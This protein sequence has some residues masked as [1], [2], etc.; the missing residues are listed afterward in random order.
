VYIAQSEPTARAILVPEQLTVSAACDHDLRLRRC[1]FP[2]RP[3]VL[4]L[5][6][7]YPPAAAWGS[8]KVEQGFLPPLGTISIYR[9]LKDKG[10]DVSFVDTQFGDYTADTLQAML[11]A[12]SYDLIGLPL[13]TSTANHVFDTAKLVRSTLPDAVIVYGGVHATSM[14]AESLEESPK[15]DFIIRREGELTIVEL[16]DALKAHATDFSAINGL[17]WRGDATTLVLNPDRRL[18]PDLD[19]LPLGMF[20][21]SRDQKLERVPSHRF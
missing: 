20:R 21:H 17:T 14:S 4:L 9:W 10:Y 11:R 8:V 3:R 18:A 2:T 13:F 6:P 19:Q 1:R 15:A 16:I 5:E 7:Y 12:G